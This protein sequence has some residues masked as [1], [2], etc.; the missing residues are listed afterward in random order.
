MWEYKTEIVEGDKLLDLSILGKEGW[1]LVAYAERPGLVG[2]TRTYILK[3]PW[4]NNSS[5]H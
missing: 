1:E 3:R 2:L 5:K 4:K